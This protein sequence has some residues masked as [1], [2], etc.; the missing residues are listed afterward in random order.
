MCLIISASF[1][2][3][4]HSQK[5]F[6]MWHVWNRS[7]LFI[8]NFFVPLGSQCV[9]SCLQQSALAA[10][11]LGLRLH[12]RAIRDLKSIICLASSLRCILHWIFWNGLWI[13]SSKGTANIIC[14][15]KIVP[16]SGHYSI[17]VMPRC[18]IKDYSL[19]KFISNFIFTLFWMLKVI[20]K[21]RLTIFE[22]NHQT[23][24]WLFSLMSFWNFWVL[25]I[26]VKSF[27]YI[28]CQS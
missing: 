1:L 23:V 26:A 20:L 19:A 22:L 12:T 8:N 14:E 25:N 21:V 17:F 4:M 13:N 5:N 7:I 15:R 6:A 24:I 2:F 28:W 18:L 3:V 9:H 16:V 10:C 27:P 11:T